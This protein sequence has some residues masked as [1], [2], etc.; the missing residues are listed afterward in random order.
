[1]LN[2]A[3]VVLDHSCLYLIHPPLPASGPFLLSSISPH[4]ATPL[5]AHTLPVLPRRGPTAGF[6]IGARPSGIRTLALAGLR[7]AGSHC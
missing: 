5:W 6:S 7:V 2:S 1:M 3:E 4:S